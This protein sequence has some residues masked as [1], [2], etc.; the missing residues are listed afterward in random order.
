[1]PYRH[2]LLSAACCTVTHAVNQSCHQRPFERSHWKASCI[3]ITALPVVAWYRQVRMGK[4][5]SVYRP[6][7]WD[8]QNLQFHSYIKYV[9]YTGKHNT[10]LILSFPILFLSV[11]CNYY[12]RLHWKWLV[13]HGM[14]K[15]DCFHY[16]QWC[17]CKQMVTLC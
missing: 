13:R 14:T 16:N 12:T 1:M 9:N 7:Q 3:T 2:S 11:H 4:A 5:C 17:R 15:I 8:K 6:F 10:C